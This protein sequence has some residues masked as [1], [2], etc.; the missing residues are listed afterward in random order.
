MQQISMAKLPQSCVPDNI[1]I[2]LKNF[3]GA[4]EIYVIHNQ[5]Q[6]AFN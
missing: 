6:V 3:I 1:Y 5:G 4:I 2:W